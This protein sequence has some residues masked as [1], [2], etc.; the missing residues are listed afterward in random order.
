[1]ATSRAAPAGRPSARSTCSAAATRAPSDSWTWTRSHPEG[2][3]R[4]R[5]AARSG[6][7]SFGPPTATA[8]TSSRAGRRVSTR[9][10]CPARAIRSASSK[11]SV[12]TPE[13]SSGGYVLVT[14]RTLTR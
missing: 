4:K 5:S 7:S 3:A 9:T 11:A 2:M 8:W 13:T 10:V 14:R 6:K 12:P 1:M